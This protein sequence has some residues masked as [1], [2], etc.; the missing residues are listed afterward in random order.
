MATY[1]PRVSIE[2]APP[3]LEAT[4]PMVDRESLALMRPQTCELLAAYGL[5]SAAERQNV[6][7]RLPAESMPRPHQVTLITGPS[8]SG[9][10]VLLRRL[11]SSSDAVHVDAS[12][13]PQHRGPIIETWP[14]VPAAE[15]ARRLAAVGLGD[16]FTWARSIDQLSVG[17]R[18]RFNLARLLQNPQ[19]NLAI[20]EWLNGLDRT[21]ARAVA[22]S[23]GRLLRR[24]GRGAIFVC[25]SDDVADD[26]CPDVHLRVGWSPDIEIRVRE[27]DQAECSI[28]EQLTY[29]RGD[30]RDWHRL[31]HL[32]YAAG[33]PATVHSY[34]VLQLPNSTE[35]AAVLI[36][37]FPDLHSAARNLATHD[38]YRIAGDRRQAQRLNREILKLSRLVVTPELRGCGVAQRLIMASLEQISARYIE[39]VTA[40]GKHSQFLARC[41]FREIIQGVSDVEAELLDWATQ[42]QVPRTVLL[43]PRGLG[44]WIDSASVRVGRKGRRL[45]WLH[46]HHLV[47]HRRTRAER[48]RKVVGPSDPRWAD[49]LDLACRRLVERPSYWVMGPLDPMT[50][51]PAD[52]P[53]PPSEWRQDAVPSAHARHASG[54]RGPM[55]YQVTRNPSPA[56]PE[57]AVPEAGNPAARERPE[58]GEGAAPSPHPSGPD[59]HQTARS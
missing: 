57:R 58:G 59:D 41:G 48:P 15:A 28:L 21:T 36:F 12:E 45:V 14:D 54:T 38:A 30:V 13:L 19:G 16:P 1:E 40:M 11:L 55:G 49:A 51:L 5:G 8:G 24:L 31:R 33:D 35:P 18:E 17:Q 26:L 7:I 32:H 27:G 23:T 10:S 37:S 47:L 46:Y 3:P 50:G 22:W 53:E 2:P 6:V 52:P 43:D 25:C 9:K 4:F 20:D 44:E 42:A 34:H 39:C 56:P 29:R